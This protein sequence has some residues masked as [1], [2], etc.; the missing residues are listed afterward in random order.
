MELAGRKTYRPQWE[1]I[2]EASSSSRL[3][4]HVESGV[5]EIRGWWGRSK[6]SPVAKIESEGAG[7]GKGVTSD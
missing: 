2:N 7:K 1:G 5:M 3:L 6:F 4:V